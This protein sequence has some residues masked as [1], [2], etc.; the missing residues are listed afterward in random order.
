MSLLGEF[1]IK[2]LVQSRGVDINVADGSGNTPL[3]LLSCSK[4][5]NIAKTLLQLGANPMLKNG[6]GRSFEEDI[7]CMS[8][9]FESWYHHFMIPREP[10]EY[11]PPY[12]GPFPQ[13]FLQIDSLPSHSMLPQSMVKK[14]LTPLSSIDQLRER[15]KESKVSDFPKKPFPLKDSLSTSDSEEGI[16][17]RV[18]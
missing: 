4:L 16:F 15:I 9:E 6:D 11:L 3:H 13:T 1:I 12:S 7:N 10:D 18:K 5:E 8:D 14:I 2:K 17:I